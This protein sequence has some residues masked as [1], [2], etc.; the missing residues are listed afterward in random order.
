MLSSTM[1]LANP[2]ESSGALPFR[3]RHFRT[4]ELQEAELEGSSDI[5]Q[6]YLLI[7]EQGGS[8]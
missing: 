5:A 4:P 2:A 8:G 7:V 6:S 3:S 1:A